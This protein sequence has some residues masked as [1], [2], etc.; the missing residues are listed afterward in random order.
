MR[1]L[2]AAAGQVTDSTKDRTGIAVLLFTGGHRGPTGTVSPP[3]S[4]R[5][6][7]AARSVTN[8]CRSAC[9][10]NPDPVVLKVRAPK[11]KRF[12]VTPTRRNNR[13]PERIGAKLRDALTSECREGP[14]RGCAGHARFHSRRWPPRARSTVFLQTRGEYAGF[15]NP[16]QARLPSGISTYSGFTVPRRPRAS[17]VPRRPHR[18]FA[19]GTSPAQRR[20]PISIRQPD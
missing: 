15:T 6:S 13:K 4:T 7:I 19:K 18:L 16:E 9:L 10:G 8:L 1:V 12:L 14:G 11:E 3:P 2:N 20:S 17:P 5:P